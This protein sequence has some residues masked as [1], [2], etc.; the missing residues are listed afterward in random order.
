MARCSAH[1]ARARRGG[2][3]WP[4]FPSPPPAGAHHTSHTRAHNHKRP[5]AVAFGL[6]APPPAAMGGG[7]GAMGG[8]GGASSDQAG[9]ADGAGELSGASRQQHAEQRRREGLAREAKALMRRHSEV[10]PGMGGGMMGGSPYGGGG[11]AYGA[12][13]GAYGGAYANQPIA[14]DEAYGYSVGVSSDV[15][16]VKPGKDT[17]EVEVSCPDRRGLGFALSRI[18]FSYGL[19]VIKGDFSTDGSWCFVVFHVT[20][21]KERHDEASPFW[22]TLKKRIE[23]ECPQSTP[24][25]LPEE[26][27]VGADGGP[28]ATGADGGA[29]AGGGGGPED[30]QFF[31]LQVCAPDRVG[32]LHDTTHALWESELNIHSTHVTTSPSNHAVDFFM[33]S[34]IR[35]EMPDAAR[36]HEVSAR[37][38]EALGDSRVQVAVSEAPGWLV[39][40]EVQR[41][42]R[43]AEVQAGGL[44]G[45][46]MMSPA[47]AGRQA[48][49]AAG[50]DVPGAA[51]G[52]SDAQ[53]R[54]ALS[55]S[56][57]E[58]AQLYAARGAH[59]RRQ[60]SSDSLTGW[61]SYGS[62]TNLVGAG[63]I[64][65]AN[66]RTVVRT[67]ASHAQRPDI[68]LRVSF[69]NTTSRAHTMV[70]VITKDRKG[71][72]YDQL[73]TIKSCNLQVSFGKIITRDDMC[74]TDLFVQCPD[75]T[76]L[77]DDQLQRELRRR[78]SRAMEEPVRIEM[79][80]PSEADYARL[81][82][83]SQVDEDGRGRPRIMWDVTAALREL[84]VGVFKASVT[85]TEKLAKLADA[86][87]EAE[88]EGGAG[89]SA[90][91]GAAGGWHGG[92]GGGDDG[93]DGD[94]AG[95]A[96]GEGALSEPLLG[97][98]EHPSDAADAAG[99]YRPPSVVVSEGGSAGT[100]RDGRASPS[101]P[102]RATEVHT[103]LL[104]DRN[105]HPIQSE[106][107]CRR[108]LN[109]VRAH[110]VGL[111]G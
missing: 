26:G 1:T 91:N 70:Q 16:K 55:S 29:R 46:F 95:A 22:T 108:I 27:D 103:F 4:R 14:E 86:E 101:R 96:G 2:V 18:M 105:G 104:T 51:A 5:P 78:F 59:H 11:G 111:G 37:I 109:S 92:G 72:L 85:S 107:D 17:T 106:A 40:E 84:N 63:A 10:V 110:L 79:V 25:L 30:R 68:G 41:L 64:D 83:T 24:Q 75:G 58:K 8:G 38:V 23:E 52:A 67:R 82:V 61:S 45:S 53:Q 62:T 57:E 19:N 90:A 35:D 56:F 43:I 6:R 39:A 69:D 87:T 93:D 13:G 50:V 34:D 77:T 28:G 71:L 47:A 42:R 97:G 49:V 102:S 66:E 60:S 21:E 65:G 3:V 73:R 15:V 100:S 76:R 81:L 98:A 54:E 44:L 31:M 32:M 74:Y 99:S 9:G 88:D 20:L 94:G 7:G 89:G 36:V 80:L 12:Y 48:S 33:I